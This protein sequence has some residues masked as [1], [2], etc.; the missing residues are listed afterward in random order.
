MDFIKEAITQNGHWENGI[1]TIA[2]ID[3]QLI[4]REI[5]TAFE[6]AVKSK[7]I[8]ILRGLRRVGKSVLA[9]QLLQKL[10]QNGA[11]PTELAWFEFDRAM[12]TTVEDLHNLIRFFQSRGAKTIVFDELAFVKGWQ[13]IVKRHYDRSELKFII[14][15]SSALELDK[16][17]AESLAGRF[18][19]IVVKPFSLGEF[20]L[21]NDSYFP[22]TEGEFVK[23]SENGIIRCDEYIRIGG[24]PETLKMEKNEAEEYVKNSLI[25]PLFFKDI[26]VVFPSANP[27]LLL[28]TLELLT[29]TVGSRYQ[30]QTI[31]QVL[32][33][34]HPTISSQI[35]ILDRSLIV[36]T[37]YNYTGS[38]IKQKRTAK[39][40]AI[41]DNAIITM[42]NKDINVGSLA[43]NLVAESMQAKYFWRDNEGKE[44]DLIFPK[45]KIAIEVKYQNII[46][47]ADEKN[48]RYFL[49]RNTGWKGIIITKNKEELGDIPAV[50][51]WKWLLLT[52][53]EYFGFKYNL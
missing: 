7:Y 35:E 39:K 42:L 40:I 33:C 36:R 53:Y 45:E 8:V 21:L 1:V 46:T 15:G 47:G 52:R 10:L 34:S 20:L 27:D 28:K 22:K 25:T 50:P 29:A 37:L 26:P 24:L 9:K 11:K 5:F 48:L 19:L 23:Y 17:S 49:E 2:R 6:N 43:E 18:K 3:G 41:A 16:R 13:D 30:L 12:G 51:L 44:I 31:A 38:L 4:Q 14:T 32:G